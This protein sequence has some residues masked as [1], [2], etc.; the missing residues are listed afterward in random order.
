MVSRVAA[1]TTNDHDAHRPLSHVA[2]HGD[3]RAS[4]PP[5]PGMQ[6]ASGDRST[7]GPLAAV[8]PRFVMTRTVSSGDRG[9]HQPD[10]PGAD[11]E[12]VLA[13]HRE[14]QCGVDRVA[15]RVEDRLDVAVDPRPVVPDVRDRQHDLLRERTVAADAE[16]DRVRAEMPAPRPA[17]AAAAAHDVALAADDVADDEV[18]DVAA[19]L[20]DLADELVA[21]DERRRD[22]PGRPRIPR[23]DVQVGAADARLAHPDQDVVDADL[24]HRHV[25]QLEAWA[26]VGL[27]ERAHRG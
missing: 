1:Q 6:P 20:H 18:L 9:C 21:D 3:E 7:V 16:P 8:I 26:G 17:M 4:V 25:A 10:R 24:G 13:E 14:R 22:R 23:L 12:H 11:H 27:H 15:E 2:A 19:E 5:P